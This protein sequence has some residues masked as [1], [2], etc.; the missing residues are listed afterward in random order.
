MV[1]L[2]GSTCISDAFG[3]FHRMYG[4]CVPPTPA[5]LGVC[6]WKFPPTPEVSTLISNGEVDPGAGDRNVRLEMFD[7]CA[8]V[9][10]STLVTPG[11]MVTY[12]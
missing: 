2:F 6:H 9:M 3:K 7:S 10:F 8:A 5:R 4:A 12:A 1:G 11:A